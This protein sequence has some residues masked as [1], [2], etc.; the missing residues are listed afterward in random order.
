[1]A[2][3][4]VSLAGLAVQARIAAMRYHDGD[5]VVHALWRGIE[6]LAGPQMT[7]VATPVPRGRG[8]ASL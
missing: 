4:P 6:R 5:E 7:Y 2:H 1:M 8:S 3:A